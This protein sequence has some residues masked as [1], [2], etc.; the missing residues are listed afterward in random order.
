MLELREIV[1]HYPSGEMSVEALSGVSIKLRKSEFVSILGPSG[2][3]KTT[4]LNIIGGLDQYTS[5]D[6]TINGK[7]TKHFKDRDWDSY[8]NHSIGFV[9]QNYH[10]IPHQTVLQNVEIALSVSGVSKRKRRKRAIE[11]LEQ[12]G[13]GDQ[14]AKKPNQ[15]SGGQMQRV[16]IARALVNDPDII[17][18]DE[19]TGALDSET[20]I[21][22]ME[23]LKE[24]A[25][26]RLVVMVTHNSTLAEA[27]ST[28]IVQMLDGKIT[29]DSMPLE[30]REI[31]KTEGEK[32]KI[33]KPSMSFVTAFMLSLRNLITKKGRTSLTAF[34][35]SIG[36]MGIALILALSQGMTSYID[37]VQEDALASYP[38]SVEERSIDISTLMDT[39]MNVGTPE[40]DHGKDAVYEKP[41][42][43]DMMSALNNLEGRE[44]DLR[45][46]KSFLEE[47]VGNEGEDGLNA[48]V[49]G[50]QYA[51]DLAFN[52]YTKDDDGNIVKSDAS[53]LLQELMVEHMEVD[54]SGFASMTDNSPMA[55]IDSMGMGMGMFT[56][57]LWQEILPGKKGEPVNEVLKKQYDLVHGTWPRSYDEIV[58]VLDKNN[59]L[60]DMTLYALGLESKEYIDSLIEAATTGQEVEASTSRWTY[61][62]I[63]QGDYRVVM[64]SD[65][66]S[67]DED[68]GLYV[69]IGQSEAGLKYLYENALV[70]KV[71]GI[72]RPNEN[73]QSTIL[74]G[75]IGYTADLTQYVIEH[76][77]DSPVIKAQK[78][79]NTID[80]LTG[81]PFESN[82]DNLT[83]GQKEAELYNYLSGLSPEGKAR[84]YLEI[85]S[86]PPQEEVDAIVKESLATYEKDAMAALMLEALSES[87][88]VDQERLESYIWSMSDEELEAL[89][90]L[91]LTEQFKAQY[92]EQVQ[93]Q[94]AMLDV[95]DLSAR[96]D[97]E[98]ENYTEEEYEVY[99]DEIMVFSESSYENNLAQM[100][101]VDRD[102]PKTIHI[103]AS[104]FENK[105][106]I[107]DAIEKYNQG[108]DELDQIQYTDFFGIMMSSVS[109]II[110]A[111][112]YVLLAFV[113]ISLIVSSIMIGVI[114]LISVQERIQEIGI[115]RA[116]G[117]SKGDISRMFNAETVIIGLFSGLIGIV[118]TYLL[119]IPINILLLRATGIADLNAYLPTQAAIILV[120]VSIGLSLVAGLIPS[121]SAAKKDPV[122]ALR[123]E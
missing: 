55:S 64:N 42:I 35:G 99:Y 10:L 115:L 29:H 37:A 112:T 59:E 86:I 109:S 118:V 117:A 52:V 34:A 47:E 61:D 51:Y 50:L 108:K 107:E 36:I 93:A 28:R 122:V 98:L 8:R 48:A 53:E 58:L 101:Y 32:E 83:A 68:V 69:D 121:R 89:F 16:A 81:L 15:I 30:E 113:A 33:K 75:A 70:L 80:I 9:F 120:L 54:L 66:Y 22:V 38:L 72:I 90:I 84:A 96:L 24:V 77:A 62:E 44:N 17:L 110:N 43:Y 82:A 40:T 3:G 1:K 106:L 4:L 92:A 60:D 39:F 100:G 74:S 102:A 45:P 114:T 63:L 116:I 76:S 18:A 14:L 105:N 27:Y 91:S 25:E 23:L 111:I 65:H 95:L 5:G 119:S 67:Y 103:F 19:P 21:Q 104:S 71:T 73:A 88:A 31:A 12:V 11:V 49:T 41:A 6:L 87:I 78:D 97:Q 2:C 85:M 94:L 123:T 56:S 20:G 46:F 26:D 57:N 79:K 13:L 7:S